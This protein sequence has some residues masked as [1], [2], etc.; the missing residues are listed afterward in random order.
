MAGA[1]QWN[2]PYST[3][4]KI[5]KFISIPIVSSS[6]RNDLPMVPKK[7]SKPRL[8]TISPSAD[9]KWHGKWDCD[10]MFSLQELHLHDLC[11]DI[12]QDTYVSLNLSVQKHAGLG[13]SVEGRIKT[14]FTTK[15][16]NCFSPYLREVH[17]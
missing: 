17:F 4:G 2:I 9:G 13:L 6:K 16:C 11:D 3:S 12:Q 1:R 5:N 15:C 14:C 7:K 10:Y 8:I